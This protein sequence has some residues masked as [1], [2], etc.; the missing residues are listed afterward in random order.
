M[1]ENSETGL[2]QADIE[3]LWLRYKK[4]GDHDAK[5]ELLLNYMNLVRWVVRRMMPKYNSFNEYDD[6][7]SCGVI[8]LIDAVDKFDIEYG[9]KFETYATTR[10]R[11]EILDYMRAQDWAPPSLRKRITAI[12][13]VLDSLDN[14]LDESAAERVVAERLEMPVGTVQKIIAQT[15]MWNI[16]NFEDSLDFSFSAGDVRAPEE[17]TPESVL[18]KKEQK[19]ALAELID[20][21]PEKERYV[22]TM[23]YYEGMLLKEIADALNVTESRVSQIHSKVLSKMRQKLK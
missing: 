22:I 5:D 20:A 23:Y 11:G 18:L 7:V 17:S 19:K 14:K 15:H 3:K 6:L 12:A 1:T 10:I 21:L 8:G 9:V 16:V 13:E 2:K 4:T